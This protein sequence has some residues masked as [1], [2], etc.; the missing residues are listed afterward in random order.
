MGRRRH[1]FLDQST[2]LAI[3][4][5]GGACEAPENTVEAFTVATELGYRYLETDAH[6]TDDKIVVAIH[7]GVLDRVTEGKGKVLEKSIAEVEAADS[8]YHFTRDCGQTYPFRGRGVRI[9]RF[10][11]LLRDWPEARFI[12]D[13]KDK[14]T[15]DLLAQVIDEAGAWDRVCLGSFSDRRLRRIRKLGRGRACTSMGPLATLVSTVTA[16]VGW[17]PRLGADCI[18]VPMRMGPIPIVTPRWVRAAHRAGLPVHVWTIDD[19]PTMHH[20]L[21]MGVDGIMT[22]RPRV[23]L[24]VFADRGL[25]VPVPPEP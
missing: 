3:A 11:Q 6:V 15:V 16:L 23:L 20:L 2:P 8:G 25:P 19:A 18:Q 14:Y 4:H 17:M 7:D 5:R 22:D 13:P 1:P 12:V 21:C 10:I 9:P 24:E